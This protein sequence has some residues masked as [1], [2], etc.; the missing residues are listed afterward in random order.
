VV[1]TTEAGLVAA[2]PLVA[3]HLAED[4]EGF[5]EECRF[6]LEPWP[7][8]TSTMLS[9]GSRDGQGSRL[10]NDGVGMCVLVPAVCRLPLCLDVSD[11]R[12]NNRITVGEFCNQRQVAAHRFHILA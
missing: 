2:A 5:L 1:E 10:R 6:L 7:R 8:A 3:R 11:T 9:A 4:P 12:Q